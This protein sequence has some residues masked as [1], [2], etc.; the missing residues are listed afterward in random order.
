MKRNSTVLVSVS[1]FELAVDDAALAAVCE[2]YGIDTL[3]VFG[4]VAR[5]EEGPSSDIDVLYALRPG[6]RLG[7]EIEDLACEL[8]RIWAAL[9][10]WCPVRRCR[11]VA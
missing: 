8:S 11:A 7:W 1:L 3:L 9:W 10:T 6:R 5:G 4:S 2:R